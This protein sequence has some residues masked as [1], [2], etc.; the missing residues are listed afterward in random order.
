MIL[1]LY[2]RLTELPALMSQNFNDVIINDYQQVSPETKCAQWFTFCQEW[3]Q[4]GRMSLCHCL[5]P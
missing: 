5:R 1:V 3:L 2:T 4:E